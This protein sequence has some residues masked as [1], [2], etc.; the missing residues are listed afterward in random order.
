MQIVQ[1]FDV[2]S[3]ERLTKQGELLARTYQ[4]E[5]SQDPTSQAAQSSRSNLIALQHTAKQMY[6]K[7]VALISIAKIVEE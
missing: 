1:E 2:G 5:L 6:G 7:A 4:A 3:I